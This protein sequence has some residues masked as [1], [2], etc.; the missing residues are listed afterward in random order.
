MPTGYTAPLHDG[1]DITFAQFV[2]RCSRAMGAAIMQRD[3]S[4]DVELAYRTMDSYHEDNVEKARL[5]LND[6]YVLTDDE[7]E[8]RQ[9]EEISK[10][11]AYRAEYVQKRDAMLR[12]YT[13][14]LSQV[15]SWTPP[16]A[17]HEGLKKFM[18]EQIEE[19]IQFDCGDYTPDV[20][21]RLP[22]PEYQSRE[23]SRLSDRLS[24]EHRYLADEQSRV[25][26]QNAWVDALRGSLA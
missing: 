4:L 1:E 15:R 13:A 14:M 2:L 16:T 7:W 9:I 24:R 3:E 26:S 18:T 17:D 25:A 10:A 6:A 5:A 8:A 11:K 23:I 21:E 19:S 12:R 20:P 22:V